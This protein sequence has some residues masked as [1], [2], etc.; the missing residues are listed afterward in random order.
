MLTE[1]AY[2]LGHGLLVIIIVSLAVFFIMYKVG[3]PVEIL[4]PPSASL[5]EVAEMRHNLGLDQPFWVQYGTFLQNAV[6]GD[7]GN[8][9]IYNQSAL[10]VVLER[11]P[12]T[13]ELAIAAMILAVVLGISLGVLAAINPHSATSR[14]IML[15]SLAGISVPTFWTGM[16]MVLLFSVT[17]GILPSSG[18]GELGQFGSFSTLDGVKHLVMP[19]MTLAL[20]QLSLILRL[21]RT[22]MREVLVQD[23]IKLARAKG[24]PRRVVI[25]RHALQNALIPV[26]T[27]IGIQFG[28]LIAFTTVTE[29]IFAWPGTG[30]LLIDSIQNLDRPVVVAYLMVIALIFVAIN[31]TVDVLYTF[32]D[33]RVRVR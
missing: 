23:Y 16:V 3:D 30:K 17:W 22:G 28:E 14:A 10:S 8:S 1:L 24:I 19:A 21:T 4:L 31:L 15:F 18:R 29:S 26:V 33:P 11:L 5:K 12:A 2:R 13:L 9:L 25:L 20:Y 27:I 7:F 6:R 32:I